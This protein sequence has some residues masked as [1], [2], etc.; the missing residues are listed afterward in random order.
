MTTLHHSTKLNGY[1]LRFNKNNG[2]EQDNTPNKDLPLSNR[3]TSVDLQKTLLKMQTHF[4]KFLQNPEKFQKRNN[5][6]T[7]RPAREER[8]TGAFLSLSLLA[9]DDFPVIKPLAPF[10]DIFLFLF[11]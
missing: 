5:E 3:Q 1:Q 9:P 6:S 7:W 4:P 11:G 10:P 2:N 8:E